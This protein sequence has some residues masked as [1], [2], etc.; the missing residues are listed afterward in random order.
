MNDTAIAR[1]CN[2]MNYI[3]VSVSEKSIQLVSVS[4]CSAFTGYGTLRIYII[5]CSM[6]DKIIIIIL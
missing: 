3:R 5:W 1:R 6:G 4:L 2:V